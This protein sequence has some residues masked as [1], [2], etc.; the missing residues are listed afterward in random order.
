ME[1]V[2]TDEAPDNFIMDVRYALGEDFNLVVDTQYLDDE[3]GV[4][5]FHR[6]KPS[7]IDFLLEEPLPAIDGESDS[8]TTGDLSSGSAGQSIA[9]DGLGIESE[10]LSIEGDKSCIAE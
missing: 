1:S 8:E 5:V 2:F 7:Y 3:H 4:R 9:S 6:A 10:G